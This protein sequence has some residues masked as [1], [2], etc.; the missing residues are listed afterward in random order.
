MMK[1][2]EEILSSLFKNSNDILI[3]INEKGEQYY[4]SDIVTEITG[5]TVEEL[6]GHILD[7]IYPDDKALI[8]EHWNRVIADKSKS[9]TIQ[10]RHKHKEKGYVWFEVVAQ[11]FL[12][13]PAINAVIANVRDITDRKQIETLLKESEAKLSNIIEQIS[14]AL[15]IIDSEGIITVWNSGAEELMD[16]SAKETLNRKLADIQYGI[17]IKQLKSRKKIE[18]MILD[19]ISFKNPSIFNRFIESEIVTNRNK[20]KTI[21]TLIFPINLGSH[22]LFGSISRDITDKN[23]IQNQLAVLNLYKQQTLSAEIY[24]IQMELEESRKTTTIAQLRLMQNSERDSSVIEKLVELKKVMSEENC[25]IINDLILNFKKSS[26]NS[27]WSEFEFL[28]NNVHPSFYEKLN[29]QFPNLTVT[30]RKLCAFLRLNMNSK[31]LMKIT[32][33]SEDAV[34]KL[35]L[36]LRKKLGIKREVNLNTYLQS[37]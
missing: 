11:S 36:R 12:D 33:Q 32:F 8:T 30:E 25:L 23:R 37:L 24:R 2:N 4:I 21:Q 6:K 20:F 19:I 5:Y 15:I 26:Y 31:E 29:Q 18:E 22:Y 28:F 1:N 10:Y 35:R 16:L 7:V 17:S 9:D 34:K 3:L 14:D 27:N 13:N